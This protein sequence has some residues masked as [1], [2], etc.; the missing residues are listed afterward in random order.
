MTGIKIAITDDHPLMRMALM[1]ALSKDNSDLEFA[2]AGSLTELVEWLETGQYCDL[3][4]LDLNMPETNGLAGLTYFRARYPNLP[5]VVFSG[6]EDELVIQTAFELG[7][8][9]FISKAEPSEVVCAAIDT[10]LRG[11][12]VA[13]SGAETPESD[14][15]AIKIGAKL[16]A[17]SPQQVRVLTMLGE[18]LLNKEIAAVLSVSPGTVKSHVT[19]L[20]DNLGLY[21]RTQAATFSLL[22]GDLE[23]ATRPDRLVR[24]A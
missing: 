23:W 15:V 11:E 13:L 2:E 4:V 17:L 14:S 21:N 16:A 8:S 5:V 24:F 7:I 19:K 1:G 10:V 6:V 22:L 18:G 3:V 9:A 12:V 20:L